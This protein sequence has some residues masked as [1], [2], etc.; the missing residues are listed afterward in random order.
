M[1]VPEYAKLSKFEDINYLC[2]LRDEKDFN[3]KFV[4]DKGVIIL[5]NC[6]TDGK[7][8]NLSK[9]ETSVDPIAF[10]PWV[11]LTIRKFQISGGEVSVPICEHCNDAIQSVCPNSQTHQSLSEHLCIHSKVCT[12]IIRDFENCWTLEG[13]L[14]LTPDEED[15]VRVEIFHKKLDK[16]CK[17]QHLALVFTKSKISILAT[18][19]RQTTPKCYSCTAPK[20]K[21]I[22]YWKKKLEEDIL[23]SNNDDEDTPTENNSVHYLLQERTYHNKKTIKF[24]LHTCEYQREIL[25]Q[26]NN[27]T[28]TLPEVLIPEYSDMNVCD[29]GNLYENSNDSCLPIL[30]NTITI[31]SSDGQFTYPTTVYYRR[32]LGQCRCI[33]QVDTHHLLLFHVGAGDLVCYRTLNKFLL[34]H[35]DSG[36]AC[37]SFHKTLRRECI[38]TGNSF[39]LSYDKFLEACDGFKT[40]AEIDIIE[41]FTCT[42]CKRDPK[43]ITAGK[44]LELFLFELSLVHLS[45]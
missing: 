38:T 45:P 8:I 9:T 25:N 7:L 6:Y 1:A 26:K 3:V 41:A 15:D 43:Y 31:Y 20:C 24:P 35:F 12:N 34:D 32:S 36:T 13:A 21:C 11:K 33:Q 27:G 19:G 37:N 23:D 44:F 16:S 5:R 14:T 39:N 17:S 30:S 40:N 28:F 29:H 10:K 4:R 42:T 18:T 2:N 22:R